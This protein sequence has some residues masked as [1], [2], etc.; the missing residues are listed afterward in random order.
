M[1]MR[2]YHLNFY[3]TMRKY[4]PHLKESSF[5]FLKK[6]EHIFLEEGAEGIMKERRGAEEPE[7]E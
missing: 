7:H 2:E 6:W 3:E 1:N 5:R 4:F